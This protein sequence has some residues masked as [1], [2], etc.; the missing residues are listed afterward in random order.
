MTGLEPR[1]PF[2]AAEVR[3]KGLVLVVPDV[4]R[5][6]DEEVEAAGE[7]AGAR[8]DQLGLSRIG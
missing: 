4:G 6:A 8:L 3:H 5:V 7:V 1:L 2:D